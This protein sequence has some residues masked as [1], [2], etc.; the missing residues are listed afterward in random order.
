M[1]VP[2]PLAGRYAFAQRIRGTQRTIIW[3]ARDRVT[4]RNVLASVL[5]APRAA[6]LE[7]IVGIEHPHA[8]S[9]L[10]V[11]EAAA[12]DEIPDDGPLEAD[13]RVAVAEYLDGGSLQQRLDAGPVSVENAVD[14]TATIA[15]A[16]TLL[17]EHAGVHGAISPR[18]ILVI[19]PNRAVVPMLVH[20]LVPPSGAYCSPERV[21]GA[22][23][24]E[25]DD[26]WRSAA[27]LYTALSRRPPF[28]GETRTEL[29]RA[30]V[31]GAPRPLAHIDSNLRAILERALSHEPRRRF[32]GA[33]ALRDA[34]RE[35]M[36]QTGAQSL[37]DFVPVEAIPG[38][39][40]MPQNVG[41]LSLVAALARPDS[42][43]ATAPLTVH[44]VEPG[45]AA[46]ATYDRTERA[47]FE[48]ISQEKT[49]TAGAAPTSAPPHARRDGSRTSRGSALRETSTLAS[50]QRR[51]SS[52]SQR[53][54]PLESAWSRVAA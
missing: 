11:F 23:P 2:R 50:R 4:G 28:R 14:W 24:S 36:D 32:P 34:L 8:A 39:A 25:A 5:P 3:I 33:A 7:P 43:E 37:G 9:V 20:L 22:G 13:A 44:S 15:D 53:Q 30:I 46:K 19:R 6:A 38:T 35:W 52:P 40:E 12:P 51:R 1:T 18:S 47:A 54:L 31:R 16:L 27:T 21:T 42:P 29:A 26:T 10:G 41:D 45:P 49:P 48:D 17:H